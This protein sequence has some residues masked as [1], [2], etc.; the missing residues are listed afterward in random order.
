MFQPQFW[1]NPFFEVLSLTISELTH[2]RIIMLLAP[3]TGAQEPT[4]MAFCYLTSGNLS[5]HQFAIGWVN[6]TSLYFRV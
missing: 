3:F 4:V 6:S 1:E 5:P 2:P